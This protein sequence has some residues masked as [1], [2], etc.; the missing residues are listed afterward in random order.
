MT[1][2]ALF[3]WWSYWG[4]YVSFLSSSAFSI[5]GSYLLQL[6]KVLFNSTHSKHFNSQPEAGLFQ[7]VFQGN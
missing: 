3:A 4:F 5:M 7:A 6:V 2:V 1:T